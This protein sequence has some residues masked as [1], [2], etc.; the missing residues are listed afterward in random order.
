MPSTVSAIASFLLI[1][2]L[3]VRGLRKPLFVLSGTL[4]RPEE[5]WKGT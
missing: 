2:L 5:E 4:E 1:T 3:L